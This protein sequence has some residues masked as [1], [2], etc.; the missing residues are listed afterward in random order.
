MSSNKACMARKER[1]SEGVLGGP[2][3]GHLCRT[4]G[5]LVDT[6]EAT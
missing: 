6:W 5:G 4:T 1:C 2:S 3:Q